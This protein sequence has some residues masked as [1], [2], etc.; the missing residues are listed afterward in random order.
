MP[1]GST[2]PRAES[3]TARLFVALWPDAG[4]RTALAIY[5][6]G[7]RWPQAARPVA[8]ENLHATLH[9]IGSFGR[10]RIDALASRLAA[11]RAEAPA[12]RPNR[13]E[14]WRGGIAVLTLQGDARL[15]AL[16]E[17]VGAVMTGLGIALDDRPFAPHVTLARKAS[18]AVAPDEWPTFDWRPDGIVLVE[19]L[20]GTAPY[21]L[22]HTWRC[23]P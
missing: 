5:R 13:P 23:A 17:Q 20:G 21:R 3:P 8:D 4:A 10:D 1:S 7:W 18:R 22:L 9:F 14:V 16:H 12:L 2:S 19:S 11:V 6:D 15:L